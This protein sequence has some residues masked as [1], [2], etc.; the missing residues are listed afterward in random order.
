MQEKITPSSDA[1]SKSRSPATKKPQ[2][3]SAP[4][5]AQ[6]GPAS[7]FDTIALLLQGGGALGA[8]QGGVYQA[9]AEANVHPNWLPGISIGAIN[10]AIIAGN[11]PERR[12]EKLRAFWEQVSPPPPWAPPDE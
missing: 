2:V 12:V 6:P 5:I 1:R 4:N 3:Q 11:A 7:Q 9:M 10:A 8:Y